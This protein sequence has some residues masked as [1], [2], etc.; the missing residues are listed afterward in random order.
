MTEPNSDTGVQSHM[1]WLALSRWEN[2]GGAGL[3]RP[4][5]GSVGP[6]L[7]HQ[8][9]PRVSTAQT[10]GAELQRCHRLDARSIGKV[11]ASAAVAARP[12]CIGASTVP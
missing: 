3:S 4:T 10:K 11:A 12:A 8:I 9:R 5:A 1:R 2:E 7:R 6:A